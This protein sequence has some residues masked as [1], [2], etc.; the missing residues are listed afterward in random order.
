MTDLITD[1]WPWVFV[2]AWLIGAWGLSLPFR[3][4]RGSRQQPSFGVQLRGPRSV[5]RYTCLNYRVSPRRR[6][7]LEEV[8]P[9]SPEVKSIY[10]RAEFFL[11]YCGNFQPDL[12]LREWFRSLHWQTQRTEFEKLQDEDI[13]MSLTAV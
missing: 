7:S 10:L 8:L 5:A 1:H 4:R 2:A 13:E 9:K 11:L 3:S 12:V 6:K